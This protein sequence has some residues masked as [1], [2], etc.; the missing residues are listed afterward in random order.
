[1]ILQYARPSDVPIVL[2]LYREYLHSEPCSLH[3]DL[4][5]HGLDTRPGIVTSFSALIEAGSVVLAWDD[6]GK[7]A[8]GKNAACIFGH[9]YC[10]FSV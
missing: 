4:G 5:G 10:T 7:R 8:L 3:L 2:T 1:M 9:Q 6:I